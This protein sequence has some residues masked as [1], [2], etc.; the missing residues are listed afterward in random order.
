MYLFVLVTFS[1]SFSGVLDNYELEVIA[2]EALSCYLASHTMMLARQ[3]MMIADMSLPS[4]MVE[5][6]PL[7][8]T[9]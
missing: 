5:I 6:R 2:M 9:S 3:S 7:G 8:K 1:S 4:S